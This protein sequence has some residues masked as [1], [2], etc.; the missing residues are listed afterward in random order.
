[1]K[2]SV[3]PIL[4]LMIAFGLTTSYAFGLVLPTDNFQQ[5]L[6][7][8]WQFMMGFPAVI[9]AYQAIVVSFC[10][11]YDSPVYYL[12]TGDSVK[13]KAVL[14]S[15]FNEE[16]VQ[17]E[18]DTLRKKQDNDKEYTTIS[19]K[20]TLKKLLCDSKYRKMVRIGSVVATVQ[21]FSGINAMIFYSSS[22]F[23][24]IGISISLSR[25][26]TFFLG[27]STVIA[28]F[29]TIPILKYIGRKPSLVSGH[30]L[31]SIDLLITGL[32]S[33]FQPTA[34]AGIATCVCVYFIFFSY[35]L[36]ATMWA[37]L[38]E[39]LNKTALS[40]CTAMNFIANI[41]VLLLFPYAVDAFGVAPTFY[42]F[43]CC[44]A[45]GA[46]YAAIDLFETKNMNLQEIELKVF[47]H[48]TKVA[49]VETEL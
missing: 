39:I 44:M 16:D 35:S 33:Q 13:Y 41:I 40:F 48:I 10:F 21:Q 7:H 22:T 9:A 8:F 31:L 29:C 5:G 1:M 4:G 18:I 38:G 34:T 12:Q 43:S 2:S 47:G 17:I 28:C 42:F 15:I 3:G 46:V 24:N 45:L 6:N 32:L 14:S 23:Q 49:A 27:I 19:E 25:F 36:Q 20:I 26:I 11:K 30:V 37:Y